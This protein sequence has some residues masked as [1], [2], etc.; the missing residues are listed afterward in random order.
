MKYHVD[1]YDK[2]TFYHE[3]TDETGKTLRIDIRVNGDL[4]KDLPPEN[5]IGKTVE[6]DSLFPYGFIGVGV[7]LIDC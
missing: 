4:E 7:K 6:I 5:L 3:C 1:S 2:Y